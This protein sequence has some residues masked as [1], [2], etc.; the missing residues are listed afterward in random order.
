MVIAR[1]NQSMKL[2]DEFERHDIGPAQNSESE[3]SFLNRSARTEAYQIRETLEKWFSYYPDSEKQEFR[4]RFRSDIDSQ[5]QAVSFELFLHELL[6]RLGY[7]ITLHPKGL[8][9]I[10]KT[11]DFLVEA[12]SDNR[13]YM[14]ATIA[15]GKSAQE[16]AAQA[17][18]NTVYDI[19][20]RAID[21][22][23]FFL[24][25]NIKGVPTSQPPTRKLVSFLK[26]NLDKLD[27]DVITRLYND[28]GVDALP[29]WHFAHESWKIEFRPIPKKE[30]ARGKIGVR[31]IGMKNHGWHLVDSRTPIRDAIIDKAG[32]YGEFSLPYI[33]AINAIGHI[34]QIDIMEAL[35]G[36]EQFTMS[37][38]QSELAEPVQYEVSRT[39]D[40]VWTSPSGPRYTRLSGV[41]LVTRFT[42]W[43][44]QGANLCLYHNPWAQKPCF[45]VLPR[46][47]QG[48]PEGN[49]MRFVSGEAL[50]TIMGLEKI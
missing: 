4:A 14:E 20:N 7:R 41:V 43:N 1:I 49:Q 8:G 5:H 45:S 30:G 46:L 3:F 9:E 6:L 28:K 23:N 32:R 18:M 40:G 39:P 50:E 33:V 27:P 37:F 16:S 31:P 38:S 29:C 10:T 25:L 44:L 47:S 35:F 26:S 34:D 19:L 21:S 11:P 15:T 36:K 17:R 48:I 42:L 22:P 2:F 24:M 13:F 12:S